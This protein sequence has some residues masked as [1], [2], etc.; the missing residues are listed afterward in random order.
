M[1]KHWIH[2]IYLLSEPAA[3]TFQA[4]RWRKRLAIKRFTHFDLEFL[5][6]PSLLLLLEFVFRNVCGTNVLRT[7]AGSK[8]G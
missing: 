7:L 8:N 5:L 1:A 2:W 6:L 4:V 3:E